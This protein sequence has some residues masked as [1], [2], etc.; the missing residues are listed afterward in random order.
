[1]YITLV[2]GSPWENTV[3]DRSYLMTRCV[4]P[5]ESRNRW[6]S[7]GG[8]DLRFCFFLGAM[9]AIPLTRNFIMPRDVFTCEHI[10]WL[11]TVKLARHGCQKTLPRR[12]EDAARI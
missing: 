6:T 4:A 8:G 2:A 5:V 11:I 3:A 9:G 12:G 10:R 1:M 7:K